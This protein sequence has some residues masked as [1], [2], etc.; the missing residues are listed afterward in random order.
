VRSAFLLATGGA[1]VAGLSFGGLVMHLGGI[2]APVLANPVAR[3]QFELTARLAREAATQPTPSAASLSGKL[4]A[5]Y[6]DLRR[7]LNY[8]ASGQPSMAVDRITPGAYGAVFALGAGVLDQPTERP[9]AVA[10]DENRTRA[11]GA[12]L[13]AAHF[14]A[15]PLVGFSG[16]FTGAPGAPSE[17]MAMQRFVQ[18][19]AFQ[20]AYRPLA[21]SPPTGFVVEDHSTT[22][23]ENVS[24]IAAMARQRGWRRVLLVTSNYHV[25]RAAQLVESS[26]VTADVVSAEALIDRALKDRALHDAICAYYATPLAAQAMQREIV[27][28]AELRA[29]GLTNPARLVP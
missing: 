12:Y 19:P 4:G 23:A 24:E 8:C 2:G 7:Q 11:L 6:D 22:T 29:R 3:E 10:G 17:A 1:L 14:G 25:P 18:S 28:I 9:T 21:T 13:A 15:A 16:G 5:A 20:A 26:D 27:A